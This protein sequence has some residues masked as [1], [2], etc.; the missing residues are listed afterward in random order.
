MATEDPGVEFFRMVR[1]RPAVPERVTIEADEGE[2]A[3]LAARFG[4]VGI[5][6]FSAELTFEPDGDAV[7]ARG[8]LK[9]Q[10][11]QACAVS[12]DDFPVDVEEP[13]SLRFVREV[14]AVDPEE[15]AELPADEPDE[16]EFTGDS[17]DIG[18]AVAQSLGLAIDPYAEGPNADAIRRE[19][20]IAPEGEAEGPLAELL[21]GLKPT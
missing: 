11:I 7:D 6:S 1:V 10:L 12:G 20:G 14:R 8:C 15:E 2:R 4:V 3:A 9:A 21:R 18:E 17:F 5:T 13:L 19:A 16:I